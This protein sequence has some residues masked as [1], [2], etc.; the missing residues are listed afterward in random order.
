MKTLS[1]LAAVL[2]NARRA[3]KL[4][5]KDLAARSGL[6]PLTVRHVLQG[7]AAVRVT[8]LMALAD[9]LGLE[10]VLV[11]KT[12]AIGLAGTR[13]SVQEP[14]QRYGPQPAAPSGA[15]T[16]HLDRLI[17]DMN[18]RAHNAQRSSKK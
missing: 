8:N 7:K 1:E 4:S 10:M 15:F 13:E 16:T 5:Y 12:V 6:T 9:E 18:A 17:G 11:P 2:E 14:L 3:Q